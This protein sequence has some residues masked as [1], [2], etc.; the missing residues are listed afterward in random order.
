MLA[1]IRFQIIEAQLP[2]PPREF[3]IFTTKKRRGVHISCSLPLRI[4]MST[5]S[6]TVVSRS[7]APALRHSRAIL[8][9]SSYNAVCHTTAIRSAS[10][11]G[12]NDLRAEGL[13]VFRFF[14]A[15]YFTRCILSRRP[16]VAS[17]YGDR[18][19]AACA[20]IMTDV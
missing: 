9:D 14:S 20:A 10:S 3:V 2:V 8:G 12:F 6:H 7:S 5:C 13:T 17:D 18:A 15:R 16:V 1:H 11:E 19:D 4:Q